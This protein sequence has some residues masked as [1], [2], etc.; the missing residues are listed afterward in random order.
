MTDQHELDRLLDAYFVDGADELA[1][2]VIAAALDQIDHTRQRRALRLPWRFSTMKMLTGAA[3]AGLIGVLAIGGTLFLTRPSQPA[4]GAQSPTPGAISSQPVVIAPSATPSLD[5][6]PSKLPT[7]GATA[8]A[9]LTIKNNP[10]NVD[11]P[12][13]SVSEAIANA[14]VG[15]QLV[16]GIALKEADG[17]VWLC[18][19]LLAS[20]P[21]DCA[22]PRLLVQN[23]LPDDQTFVSGTGLHIAGGVRW[24][25]GIQLYGSVRR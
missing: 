11:G 17:T 25:D 19:A 24:A 14:G 5:A 7:P 22:E 9:T 10:G 12:G 1:D 2:R 3:A 21:P 6:R 18:E 20:S 4:V 13:N 15:L 16:N 23:L 8:P